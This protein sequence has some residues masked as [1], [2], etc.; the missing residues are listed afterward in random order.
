MH[1]VVEDS[2]DL[3][4]PMQPCV[5]SVGLRLLGPVFRAACNP[6]A[7]TSLDIHQRLSS[8]YKYIFLTKSSAPLTRWYFTPGQSCDR[9]PLTSTTECCCTLCPIHQSVFLHHTQ[10]RHSLFPLTFPR[11]ISPNKRPTTQP[12]PRNLTLPRIRFLRL[13]SRYTQ[14]HPLQFGPVGKGG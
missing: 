11:Y 13:H 9:P 4:P 6:V 1:G 14:A 3:V 10:T 2:H 12:H 7:H 5:R 8:K